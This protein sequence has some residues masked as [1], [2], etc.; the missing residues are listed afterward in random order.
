MKAIRNIRTTPPFSNDSPSIILISA[1]T[2]RQKTFAK[3]SSETTDF[4]RVFQRMKKALLILLEASL[5]PDVIQFILGDPH[6]VTDT[7]MAWLEFANLTFIGSTT[8]FEDL[9]GKIDKAMLEGR[10]NSYPRVVGETGERAF[11]KLNDVIK[12]AKMDR[13]LE[14]V[15]GG[16]AIK[17]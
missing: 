10:L 4:D 1:L 3:G 12:S 7:V 11:D 2:S 15:A 16:K 8:T 6:V 5:P 17:E 9:Q 13:K 14:L